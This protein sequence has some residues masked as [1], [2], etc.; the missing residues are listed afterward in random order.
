[1]ARKSAV[2]LPTSASELN[3]LMAATE[4]AR[5]DGIDEIIST[6]WNP[7]ACPAEF[8][9][10]LAWALSVDVYDDEWPED[11]KREVIAASPMVH[12]RKGTV[13]AVER[14][15]K[16]LGLDAIIKEWHLQEPIGRRGTFEIDILFGDGSSIPT[17]RSIQNAYNSVKAS[18][19]KSRVFNL[20]SVVSADA[21]LYVA[22][23][24]S[25]G[26]LWEALP[27]AFDPPEVDAGL[28]L[29]VATQ[30]HL[31]YEANQ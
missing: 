29:S 10:F 7:Y 3:R 2:I 16:A 25:I 11:R 18:K 31:L 22:A 5:S 6:L 20:R 4:V 24:P 21:G 23:A 26:L 13:D 19:P 30:H 28:P 12:R 27:A 17:P 15:L 9:P 8:L 14:A 1:M